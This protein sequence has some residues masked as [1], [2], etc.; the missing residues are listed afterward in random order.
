MRQKSRLV[1]WA[2]VGLLL[3]LYP[4]VLALSAKA[5]DV[6]ISAPMDLRNPVTGEEGVWIPRWAERAHVLDAHR[7]KQCQIDGA[8]DRSLVFELENR[9]RDKDGILAARE[10]A[11]NTVLGE[12]LAAQDSEDKMR[13]KLERRTRLIWGLTGVS[14]ALA[15]TTTTLVLLP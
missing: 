1:F 14:L 3:L 6:V 13:S 9:A 12:S 5:Q 10:H 8:F 4:F 11:L 15:L 7:L 2:L